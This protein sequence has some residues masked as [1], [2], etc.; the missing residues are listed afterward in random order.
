MG[1]PL[2]EPRTQ[3]RALGEGSG[4]FHRGDGGAE[5]GAGEGTEKAVPTVLSEGGFGDRPHISRERG[6]KGKGGGKG[7][8]DEVRLALF[9][10]ASIDSLVRR[11]RY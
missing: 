9:V 8:R 2:P 3:Q 1:K 7:G 11:G 4:L 6:R 5:S 10:P